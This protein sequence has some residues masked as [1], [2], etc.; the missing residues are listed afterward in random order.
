MF[1]GVGIAVP[2]GV[3]D[4][5]DAPPQ[6]SDLLRGAVLPAMSQLMRQ[7]VPKLRL[8]GYAAR[9][10]RERVAGPDVLSQSP[11]DAAP[12]TDEPDRRSGAPEQ[13][14]ERIGVRAGCD[15]AV[16]LLDG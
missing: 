5:R 4:W 16:L 15:V 11:S 7:C 6:R 3:A 8:A 14:V 13:G 2:L 12:L 10:Q 1:R 9:I